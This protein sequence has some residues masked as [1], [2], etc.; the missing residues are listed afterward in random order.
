[1]LFSLFDPYLYALSPATGPDPLDASFSLSSPTLTCHPSLRPLTE[2]CIR[3]PSPKHPFLPPRFPP[4]VLL[5]FPSLIL[6]PYSPQL[7]FF[8]SSSCPTARRILSLYFSSFFLPTCYLV[9]FDGS[10]FPLCCF[11]PPWYLLPTVPRFHLVS[12]IAFH[13]SPLI[14]NPG[15]SLPTVLPLELDDWRFDISSFSSHWDPPRVI[16]PSPIC[17]LGILPPTH[18]LL[19]QSALTSH[20]FLSC[21]ILT[22][23]NRNDVIQSLPILPAYHC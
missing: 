19:N 14:A 21:F 15:A 17:C 4:P 16:R 11:S 18:L 1:V 13:D 7:S 23:R 8:L 20:A 12:P 22:A 3:R 6:I 5:R 9:G 2:S 10:L